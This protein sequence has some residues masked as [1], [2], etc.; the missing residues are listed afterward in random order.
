MRYAQAFGLALLLM[1]GPNA[2]A[3]GEISPAAETPSP[4]PPET[5]SARTLVYRNTEAIDR[6]LAGQPFGAHA[7]TFDHA[8]RTDP[9][10]HVE[11]PSIGR[12]ARAC[13]DRLMRDWKLSSAFVDREVVSFVHFPA[14]R[15]LW[16]SV[17]PAESPQRARLH[18]ELWLVIAGELFL[19]GQ[20]PSEAH[21]GDLV[22]AHA[23]DFHALSKAS[24]DAV[25][26][27]VLL[28]PSRPPPDD[29]IWAFS[30]GH[31]NHL[32]TADD[33]RTAW[34]TPAVGIR[35][36]RYAVGTK[37][38]FGADRV[39]LEA[40]VTI[41]SDSPGQEQQWYV[42]SGDGE[43][44]IGARAI[45]YGPGTVLELPAGVRRSLRART[46]T[47]LVRVSV[48]VPCDL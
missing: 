12:D 16:S 17:G 38:S 7:I 46:A 14:G 4:P 3:Q 18:D 35:Q 34:T 22:F 1:R 10:T 27:K 40:G 5:P 31:W 2:S 30:M 42:V 39:A 11:A 21:P 37:P 26:W 32:M 9:R 24:P 28:R 15:R 29:H 47:V 36:K 6:C 44:A 20:G 48:L 43:G 8:T 33:A 19:G 13:L 23:E 41:E 25:V 45:S